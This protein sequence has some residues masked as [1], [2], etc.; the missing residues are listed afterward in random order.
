MAEFRCAC[1][2]PIARGGTVAWV[3][4]ALAIAVVVSLALRVATRP[5]ATTV[6][7]GDDDD[8][9]L[10]RRT[11]V[12]CQACHGIDGRGVA[13]YAPGLIGAPSLAGDGRAAIARVLAGG[14]GPGGYT[15]VMPAFARLSDGEIAAVLSYARNAW[16]GGGPAIDAATV[17]EVRRGLR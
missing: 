7:S 6:G 17:A 8:A 4:L 14:P 11:Y 3:V 16:G 15:A 2:R 9:P 10:G 12:N 13:G 5:A 1:R